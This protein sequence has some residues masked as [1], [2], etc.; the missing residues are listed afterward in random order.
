MVKDTRLRTSNMAKT[1]YSRQARVYTATN[2]IKSV[3]TWTANT[4]TI[5]GKGLT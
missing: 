3:Y 1:A 2:T 4:A 5:I